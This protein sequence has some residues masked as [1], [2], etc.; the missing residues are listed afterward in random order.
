MISNTNPNRNRRGIAMGMVLLIGIVVLV[1]GMAMITN[2]GGLLQNSVDAKQ[3]IRSRFAAEGMIAIELARLDDLKNRNLG[4]AL[5]LDEIPMRSMMTGNGEMAGADPVKQANASGQELITSGTFKGMSGFRAPFVIHTTATAPGGAKTQ[6]D[7]EAYLFQV[8]IFQFGVFYD[9]NLEIAPGP[10][11]TVLGPVHTNGSA[12]FRSSNGLT[13][14]GPITATGSIYHWHR[15]RADNKL[16]YQL[17]PQAPETFTPILTDYVDPMKSST[18]PPAVDGIRNVKQGS[19]RLTLPIGNAQPRELILPCNSS[20]AAALKLQKF[21]CLIPTRS[22]ARF[23]Y[24]GQALPRWI[25]GPKVFFDRR[26]DRW[27]KF[28]D[29]DVALALASN[30][31]DSIFYMNDPVVVN[32]DRGTKRSYMLNAF[33]LV[34]GATLARNASF[35]SGNPVY[36]LGDFNKAN[37]AGTCR[38]ADISGTVDDSLKYC[39]AMIAADAVT[40]L[41]PRWTE[42]DF[43]HRGMDGSLEQ[44]FAN[45]RWTVA[46]AWEDPPF[47]LSGG[48][49]RFDGTEYTYGFSD[50]Y[51]A[52]GYNPTIRLNAAILAGNKPTAQHHLVSGESDSAFD[53]NYEG[54]WHNTLR[55]LEDLGGAT[56]EFRGS[57]VCL[58]KAA[59][60]GLDTSSTTTTFG[61]CS[62]EH[63]APPGRYVIRGKGFFAPPGRKWGFDQRFTNINNMP[64]G[65][66]FLSTGIFTN[67]SERR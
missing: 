6:I 49:A 21:D 42:N 65:T 63:S 51:D 64:P 41:S 55:F 59:T 28:W 25:S 58:W 29:F 66:P 33:R 32:T 26:E 8:P 48:S 31:R 37:P 17:T 23:I 54:G 15:P 52:T 20:D 12:Y 44:S 2:S 53:S 11:M 46:R 19:E 43:A 34:N 7:A 45:P 1:L 18:E 57:F 4:S 40:L 61:T 39:N 38:P 9:G 67:W 30:P 16:R 36:I 5:T 24:R 47:T 10:D 56:V 35:V 62:V 60:L 14:Q 13:F 27:V 22:S 50:D 3:R